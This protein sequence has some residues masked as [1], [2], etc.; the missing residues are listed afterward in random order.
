VLSIVP[1]VA[2][3]LRITDLVSGSE[4]TPA[5]ARFFASP[6]PV[7]AHILGAT[8]YL[9]LGAF[10][11][12][13]RLRRG[14]PSWHRIAGRILVPA[15]LVAALSG[16]WMAVFYERP[17][18]DMVARLVFGAAMAVSILLGLRAVLRRDVATHRAWMIRGYAIGIGAGTQ[19]LVALVWI[20]VTGGGATDGPTTT[21]LLVVGWLI[22]LAVAEAVIRRS[23]NSMRP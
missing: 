11:F 14:R 16:M 10:Q 3:A 13:P 20:L 21:A 9:V 17:V 5:N 6:I 22:N 18:Y 23:I 1:V 4:V 7:V 12:V 2:G 8:T 19:V 15:G